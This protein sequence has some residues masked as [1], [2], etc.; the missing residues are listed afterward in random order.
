[1]E[2]NKMQV[3]IKLFDDRIVGNP[4]GYKSVK[5]ASVALSRKYKGWKMLRHY[6]W[7][8]FDIACN[9]GYTGRNIYSIGE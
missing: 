5:S 6:I 9:N 3:Y 1:M 7:N 8:E 2:Q 4:K